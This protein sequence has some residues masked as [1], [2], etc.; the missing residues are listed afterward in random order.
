MDKKVVFV[1]DI[2]YKCLPHNR[3]GESDDY[4]VAGIWKKLRFPAQSI[5]P[6]EDKRNCLPPWDR[7]GTAVEDDS[8]FCEARISK[9]NLAVGRFY[10]E[11][12]CRA[13][14][15]PSSYQLVRIHN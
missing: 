15:A 8:S 14:S 12:W 5:I 7:G 13:V 4:L 3:A 6:I 2:V 10:L 11:A 9:H 1:G